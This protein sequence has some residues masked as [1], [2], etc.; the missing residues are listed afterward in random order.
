LV[1]IKVG[2]ATGAHGRGIA[3]GWIAIGDL[4]FG[5]IFA[6]G[7]I[8]MG[9]IA[10][11]GLSMG[12]LSFGGAALG[13]YAFGGLAA[14]YLAMGGMAIAYR[15][16]LGG[17]AVA[18][19]LAI[20]GAA[21]VLSDGGRAIVTDPEDLTMLADQARKALQDPLFYLSALFPLI[22]LLYASRREDET[23]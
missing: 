4:A 17:A 13:G 14:G 12:M 18:G 1:H 21:K 7:G 20:G 3:L 2:G 10:V 15:A 22:P 11:G 5:V 16:A 19:K 9:G 23:I 8:A 6:S